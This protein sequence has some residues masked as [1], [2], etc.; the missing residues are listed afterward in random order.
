[1]KLATAILYAIRSE[2][3][4]S[5]TGHSDLDRS[6][7]SW[8]T[9]LSDAAILADIEN[10]PLARDY[11]GDLVLAI[12]NTFVYDDAVLCFLPRANCAEIVGEVADLLIRCTDIRRVLCAALVNGDL[13]LSARTEGDSD[14]A[15]SLLQATLNGIGG[16]GGHAHR[17]GAFSPG[18][19]LR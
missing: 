15:A 12:Q 8:L 5:E 4:G 2:T 11:F 17:A 6:V 9:D 16:C 10:A 7:I 18:R 3:R 19:V 14:S 13:L 1:M